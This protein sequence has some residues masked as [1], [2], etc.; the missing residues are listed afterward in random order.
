M[1]QKPMRDIEVPQE[2]GLHTKS[3]DK[4]FGASGTQDN[5]C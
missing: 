4:A 1:A 3:V 2:K 5:D